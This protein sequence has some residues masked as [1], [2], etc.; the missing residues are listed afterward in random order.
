MFMLISI[1]AMPFV[2]LLSISLLIITR[3]QITKH[4]S[5]VSEYRISFSTRKRR[6][7]VDLLAYLFALEI[8][9]MV[10]IQQIYPNAF[11]WW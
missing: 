2:G 10:L 5:L 1:A 9:L 4:H 3:F 7:L 11:N 8:V 6:K